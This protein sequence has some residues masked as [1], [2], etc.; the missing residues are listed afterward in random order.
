MRQQSDISLSQARVK[1]HRTVNIDSTLAKRDPSFT[2]AT[3]NGVLASSQA[4]R[5]RID[6]STE[7]VPQECAEAAVQSSVEAFTRPGTHM[8]FARAPPIL[9]DIAA[10]LYLPHY[11]HSSR[12]RT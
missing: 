9:L 2:V 12:V 10:S 5:D 11:H 7:C 6:R 3:D 8:A 1:Y 4:P